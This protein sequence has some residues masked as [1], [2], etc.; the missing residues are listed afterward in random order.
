MKVQ[1]TEMGAG[2]KVLRSRTLAWLCDECIEKEPAYNLPPHQG[3]PGMLSPA[4]ERVRK[5][6]GR[7]NSDA[8]GA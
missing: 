3:A 6:S 5:I 7:E 2:A 4:L 8:I 1:F